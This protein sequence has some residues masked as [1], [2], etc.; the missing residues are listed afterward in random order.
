MLNQAILYL[1]LAATSLIFLLVVLDL[2]LLGKLNL[3][4]RGVTDLGVFIWLYGIPFTISFLLLLIYQELPKYL[5]PIQVIL[6]MIYGSDR[7][8]L[9]TRLFNLD[10]FQST[11]SSSYEVE[12]VADHP[13]SCLVKFVNILVILALAIC[14]ALWILRYQDDPWI[15]YPSVIIIIL[16]IS[17]A[18]IANLVNFVNLVRRGEDREK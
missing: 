12:W 7:R 14:G 16:A 10:P 9:V 4:R 3:L 8:R 13:L 5:F 11:E 1:G 15:I 18:Q 17:L 2:I 6:L